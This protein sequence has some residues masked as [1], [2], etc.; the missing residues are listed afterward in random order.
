MSRRKMWWAICSLAFGT[1]IACWGLEVGRQKLEEANALFG[2][3]LDEGEKS[4][5][6][7]AAA[8]ELFRQFQ[9][10]CAARQFESA[11]RK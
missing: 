5:L 9:G 7:L 8:M 6:R 10:H 11:W 2:Q 3:A 1:V 4:Q